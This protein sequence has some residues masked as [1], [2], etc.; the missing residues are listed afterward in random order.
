MVMAGSAIQ[1][2][3]KTIQTVATGHECGRTRTGQTYT[4]QVTII[5]GMPAI[6]QHKPIYPEDVHLFRLA[7]TDCLV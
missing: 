5:H 4:E 6:T 2:S 1:L 3:R 7:I